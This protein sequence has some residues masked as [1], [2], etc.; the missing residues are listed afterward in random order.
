MVRQQLLPR[1]IQD[2]RVLK[3]M[4]QI[5]R[6]EFV[7]S[8]L[9]AFAY[10]DRPLPIG[11]EQT[12]S[13][14]CIVALMTAALRL[15]GPERVLEIGTGSGYQT[16]VLANLCAEVYSIERIPELGLRA[17]LTLARLGIDNVHLRVANGTAGWPE[18]AP[19][20]AVLVTAGAA[21]L[22]PAY[23][24]QILPGGRLVIPLGPQGAQ[25]LHRFTRRDDDWEDENLGNVAFVPLVSERRSTS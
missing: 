18:E 12:I 11:Y 9:R 23:R 20:D 4:G 1:G 25:V 16:A 17:E 2:E 7:P 15:Q 22:P 24:E 8:F 5:P 21:S 3:V 14:P 10:D 19:F 13:Q 6:E